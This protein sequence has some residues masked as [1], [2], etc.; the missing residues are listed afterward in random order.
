[1]TEEQE[2][3]LIERSSEGHTP[4]MWEWARD[5]RIREQFLEYCSGAWDRADDNRF[6]D[7]MSVIQTDFNGPWIP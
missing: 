7:H 4:K 2:L 3:E 5:R 6:V 1:M